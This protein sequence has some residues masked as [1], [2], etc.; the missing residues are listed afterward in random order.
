M[1]AGRTAAVSD[2]HTGQ[3][4]Q[5]RSGSSGGLLASL[6]LRFQPLRGGEDGRKAEC[7]Q[8]RNGDLPDSGQAFGTAASFERGVQG[9]DTGAVQHP[10]LTQE[11]NV[12]ERGF[13]T[14]WLCPAASASL[15][16]VT[17]ARPY[18]FRAALTVKAYVIGAAGGKTE[19]S[20]NLRCA[21]DGQFS[22]GCA[23]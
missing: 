2:R 9:P 15:A 17:G 21:R 6:R 1:Q 16:S 4:R 23:R 22:P 20:L 7:A 12:S 8:L 10:W 13:S 3:A 14:L 19:A 11:K 5:E 18:R